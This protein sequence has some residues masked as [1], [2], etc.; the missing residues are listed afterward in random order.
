MSDAM[1]QFRDAFFEE[2]TELADGMEAT[3]LSMDLAAVEVEDLHTLFRAAH[4]IKGNAATFGFPAV[5]AFTHQLESTLEPVR[6][7][8]R[9]MTPDLRELMLQGVDLIR[10]HLHHA[11]RGEPLPAKEQ[12]SQEALMAKL[13]EDVSTA[14]PPAAA[15]QAPARTVAMKGGRGFSIRFEAPTDSFR[16]GINLERLFRDLAKLG[17]LQIWPDLTR[18]PTFEQMDPE[19][20]H[21]AWDIRLETAHPQIDVDDIFEF[22]AEGDNLRIQPLSPE[23]A[24][25]SLGEILQTEAGVSPAD[26][27]E[28]L[29][30]QKRLGELLVDMGKVKPEVVTKALDQQQK[31]RNQAEASTVRVATDKIDRLVN[32]VGELVIT[33]AMLAQASQQSN[34]M[35]GEEQLSAALMQ[36]DRQTRELQERV[37]GIRMVPVEMVF[38]RFPRMVHELGKQLGKDV[39]LVM[40]GQ[41]TELDKT[42]IEMLVDPL[43]HLV[44]NAVDHGMEDKEERLK[45]GKPAMG[46]I[47]LRA[48]SRGG[49]IHIEVK[50]DGKGLNRDRIH[51]KALDRGLIQPG[52]RPSDEEL[53]LLIFEPGFSTVEQVSDL[54]GRGVGM[55]VVK[56]NVRALGGRIEVESQPG[57]G[58]LIRLVL[59][60]TLAILDGLTVRVAEETYVFPLASVLESFQTRGTDVQTVKGDREVISLRGEFIPVVRL[61]RLLAVG[62]GQDASDRTLLV[63]VESEG[64]RAAMA[65]DELLGQQQVVIKSLETHYRR[66][67][68][69]SG[70]TILGDGRVAL[71]LDVPGLMRLEAGAAAVGA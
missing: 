28:A 32:L 70:A 43:T 33:Q 44:R 6:Q 1:A 40:E 55:D 10:S 71:I 68:G 2:A 46:T 17:T 66:V 38:S 63:L 56:Q 45:T 7:G 8:T 15:T 21:L 69:I 52:L 41:A 23:G 50:D 67:E 16:R 27:R 39:E 59:P 25:P 20:C 29:S 13:Q 36:L 31:K 61:Q 11:R 51:Q 48:S 12:Q 54:S 30:Q 49:H 42:F 57:R 60:L 9:P 58:T 34:T 22:V 35:Q 14:P 18:I 37:M 65:V 26:I 64:R 19:D 53:N 62:S 47:A 24:V 3:L 4:S 5:A